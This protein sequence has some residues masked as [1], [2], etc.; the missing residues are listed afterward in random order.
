M[1]FLNND[2]VYLIAEIGVNHNGDMN[3]AKTLIRAAKESGADAVKF[4]TFLA[5]KLVSPG[6]PKVAYQKLT[7]S[8]KQSHF[9]MIRSLELSP[10][11]HYY[12]KEYCDLLGIE[13]LSTPYDIESA[14]LLNE[15]DVAFFKTCSADITDIPLHKYIASTKKPCVIST[16]MATLGEIETILQEYDGYDGSHVALL[17][18][19]SNYPCSDS[20]INMNVLK[21]LQGA[22]HLPIGYSDHGVGNVAALLSVAFG[23]R[24]I[25]KHFTIDKSLAGP[26]HKASVTPDEFHSLVS[27]IRRAEKILGSPLKRCQNEEREMASVSRKSLVIASDLT[28]GSILSEESLTLKRP[29]TGLSSQYL[30]FFIGK[31]LVRDLPRNHLLSIGDVA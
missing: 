20:S 15:L 23:A 9:E 22:F 12:L 25:E 6:T 11:N 29:G 19:V 24:I 5:E 31:K 4:Q 27:E 28:K 1:N 30:K 10:S 8:G 18:C 21:T 17:H 2:Q 7:T 3:L 16:G 14:K 13:F 26:D